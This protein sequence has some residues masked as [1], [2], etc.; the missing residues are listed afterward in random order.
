MIE[1][2]EGSSEMLS[3]AIHASKLFRS[4]LGFF[5]T[6]QQNFFLIDLNLEK[7]KYFF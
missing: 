1:G 4:C 6:Q 2:F 3:R 5:N 7:N